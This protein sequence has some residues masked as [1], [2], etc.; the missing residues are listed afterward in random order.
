VH[1]AHDSG[2]VAKETTTQTPQALRAAALA[3]IAAAAMILGGEYLAS[4]GL[5]SS[6][7]DT[8]T[9]SRWVADS[10]GAVESGVYYL[11]VPGALLFF[12]PLAALTSL[13]PDGM[14]GRLSAW[15]GQAFVVLLAA[16][17]VMQSTTASTQGFFT[18]FED[19]EAATLLTG[20]SAGF[21]PAIVA[22]WALAVTMIAT[23]VGLHA[24]GH[25]SA[26]FRNASCLWGLLT[27]VAGGVGLG[28]VPALL[29]IV[30][31]SVVLLRVARA[32]GRGS[33]DRSEVPPAGFEPGHPAQESGNGPSNLPRSPG[34]I[35]LDLSLA[36]GSP[37][38]GLSTSARCSLSRNRGS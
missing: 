28:V 18:A 4:R 12:I 32:H 11:I 26:R 1:A 8:T 6:N 37:R 24:G 31:L 9:W 13:Q 3:G 19:P 33:H 15:G 17:A 5:P 30:A 23:G 14:T 7:A 36:Q 22:F 16:S 21:H 35:R 2:R 25:A 38:S 29:W 20:L 27:L 34:S 10:E